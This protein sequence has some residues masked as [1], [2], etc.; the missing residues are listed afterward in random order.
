[1]KRYF[2]VQYFLTKDYYPATRLSIFVLISIILAIVVV[3][4]GLVLKLPY[5]NTVNSF[6]M[7]MNEKDT[8]INMM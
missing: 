4:F 2:Q 3:T 1:M 7:L 8:H 6:Y 5:S